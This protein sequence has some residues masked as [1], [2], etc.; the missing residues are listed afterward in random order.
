MDTRVL[1]ER[2]VHLE[3]RIAY[4]DDLLSSLDEV[5]REFAR[6]VERLETELRTLR[7]SVGPGD[8][9]GPAD[10]PPPHY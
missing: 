3:T 1:T 7:H 4:Q 6:R 5:V 10:E 9:L 8:E 2:I